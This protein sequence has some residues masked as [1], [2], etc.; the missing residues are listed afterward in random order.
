[1]R[2]LSALC[3]ALE[4]T[5]VLTWLFKT[6]HVTFGRSDRFYLLTC[7]HTHRI[8]FTIRAELDFKNV[9]VVTAIDRAYNKYHAFLETYKPI[10]P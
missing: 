4:S 3:S 8:V 2:T 5:L 9:A 6:S 7:S 1:M 10:R